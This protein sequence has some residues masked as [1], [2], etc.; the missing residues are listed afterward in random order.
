VMATSG[1]KISAELWRIVSFYVKPRIRCFPQE[2]EED[3]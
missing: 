2:R 3:F 1:S